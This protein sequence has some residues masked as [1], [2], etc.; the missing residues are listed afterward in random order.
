M[1]LLK[2]AAV[3]KNRSLRNAERQPVPLAFIKVEGDADDSIQT[4]LPDPKAVAD[5]ANAVMP[6][7]LSKAEV[8]VWRTFGLQ[9]DDQ[10]VVF[11][12]NG[13]AFDPAK[14]TT[15]L[16]KD[17]CEE[18]TLKAI[19]GPH[20]SAPGHPFHVHV[21]PFQVVRNDDNPVKPYWSDTIFIAVGHFVTVRTKFKNFTGRTV[22]HCHILDHEDAGLRT[23]SSSRI[24][25]SALGPGRR[26]P[27]RR[28][29]GALPGFE[30]RQWETRTRWC[31]P[32]RP[33]WYFSGSDLPKLPPPAQIVRGGQGL[34]G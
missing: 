11:E 6:A 22:L 9:S 34:V 33:C 15:V 5:K 30:H 12:I 26:C 29:P 16:L 13:T 23:A 17:S 32:E 28:V 14:V 3:P 4:K 18:W 31:L 27:G 19:D 1:F 21:N 20:H 24:P 7:D 10:D 8:S 2:S 25:E